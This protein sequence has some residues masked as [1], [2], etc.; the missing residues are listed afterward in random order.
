[1]LLTEW[2]WNDAL[3]VSRDE[4]WED[5]WEKGKE[6]GIEKG[7]KEAIEEER[8]WIRGLLKQAKS[9]DELERMIE[10]ALPN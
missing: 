9:M 5:G 2:N 6:D 8:K 3:Q 7:K 1:M 4:G 10:A